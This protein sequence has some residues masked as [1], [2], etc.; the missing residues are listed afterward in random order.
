[1]PDSNFR[2][3]ASSGVVFRSLLRSDVTSSP[4]TGMVALKAIDPPVNTPTSVVPPPMSTIAVPS[5][6]S[7]SVKT[8]RPE[9]KG[10]IER[11]A[12]FVA[13]TSDQFLLARETAAVA[14]RFKS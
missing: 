6:I 3:S 5:S 9:A 10:W 12:Q 2:R 7:S 8:P 11:G 1:M 14:A 13:V 4:A